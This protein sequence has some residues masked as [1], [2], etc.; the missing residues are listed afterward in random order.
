MKKI[1]YLFVILFTTIHLS[2]WAQN[3]N[4]PD[5]QFEEFVRDLT[6]DQN[7]KYPIKKQEQFNTTIGYR[8]I[9]GFI[10]NYNWSQQI[11]LNANYQFKKSWVFYLNQSL[12]CQRFI[13]SKGF[14]TCLR[15]S[16]TSL[17][18]Q[19]ILNKL[20]FN[21]QARLGLSSTLPTS[22]ISQIER[23]QGTLNTSK[24]YMTW[25][26]GL[27]PVLGLKNLKIK[28]LDLFIQPMARYYFSLYKS[29]PTGQNSL[30]G[31]P[32]PQ[33]SLGIQRL[34]L[35]LTG[36]EAL[37]F[38][39]DFGYWMVFLYKGQYQR[40]KHSPY[41]RQYPRH[42]YN[43]SLSGNWQ[44]TKKLGLSLSYSLN[45]RMDKQ[46][47]KQILVFDDRYSSWAFSVYY[48]FSNKAYKLIEENLTL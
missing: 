48:N 32:L 47:R 36:T 10:E 6:Y 24:L 13:N 14:D 3:P 19:K 46:G 38:S 15:L 20:P 23:L 1:F 4:K 16:D 41:D 42:I 39:M 31:G 27:L 34:A 33:F 40:N 9:N 37:S 5:T 12:D 8:H 2:S 35:S 45:D 44:I 43:I 26:M 30:G 25:S 18:L 28:S 22:A 29:T 21:S 11:F 7:E 17:S